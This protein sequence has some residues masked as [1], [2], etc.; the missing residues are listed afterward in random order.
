MKKKSN[1]LIWVILALLVAFG[2]MIY[3]YMKPASSAANTNNTD[4]TLSEATVTT[5]T[6]TK[7]ISSSSGE[8][9]TAKTENLELNTSR[10]FKEIYVEKNDTVKAG[11]NILQYTNGT[12]LTAPYNCIVSEVSIPEIGKICTSSNYIKIQSTEEL[13]VTLS[14]GEADIGTVEVGQEAEITIT[15]NNKR[16]TGIIDKIS[17]V[18][19]YSTSGSTFTAYVK[20][21]ND[22]TVKLGMSASCTVILDKAENV[23]AVPKEAIQTAN[24]TNYVV[25][26]NND[27][28]TEN[29][30][31]QTGLSNDAYTEVK[32]GLNLGERVQ[33]TVSST[34]G[35]NNSFRSNMPGG[36][37]NSGSGPQTIIMSP[38]GGMRPGG[39]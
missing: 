6:I 13:Y 24:N 26:V 9:S 31:V 19:T 2:I 37:R 4:G 16:Y 39:N 7:S 11:E 22:E 20:F 23:L 12:Y 10:Y 1:K 14:I 3:F 29:V 35:G 5:Q 30:T 34:N 28:T 8:I 25:V 18:G 17:D 21:I 32:T 33:Y 15:A 36:Q 38:D 27:G